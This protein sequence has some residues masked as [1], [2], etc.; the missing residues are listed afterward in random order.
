MEFALVLPLVAIC[1][2][3]LAGVAGLCLQI[4]VL[5]DTARN[6]VRAAITADDPSAAAAA[7]AAL[8]DTRSTTT[9]DDDT[10]T[11]TVEVRKTVRIPVP[12]LG[13]FLG[14]RVLTASATMLREPPIALG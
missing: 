3:L 2:M 4:I 9:V 6:A 1:G 7:V 14:P 12:L 11:V 10:H 13:D 5:Q 8:V